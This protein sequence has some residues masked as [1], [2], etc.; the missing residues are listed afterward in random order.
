MAIVGVHEILLTPSLKGFQRTAGKALEGQAGSVGEQAGRTMG[1][2]LGGAL[3]VGAVAVGGAAIAGIGVAITKGFGRLQAIEQ[4]Q[5]TLVG[6]GHSAETVEQ[7]MKNANDAVKG[8]AFGLGDAATVAAQMVASGIKPGEDLE[9]TLTLVG[10]AATIAG[11]GID[12]MGGIFAKAAASNKVQ[13]DVIGQLHDAG[14]PALQ[15]IA[16]EMGVTAEEASKMASGGKVDFETFEAAMTKGMGGAAQESGKTLTGAFNNAMAAV[17]RFGA[18]LIQDVYPQVRDFFNGFIEWMGPVEELG[19]VIGEGLGKALQDLIAW[20]Q[21]TGMPALKGFGDWV[22]ENKDP[23]LAAASA[24]AGLMAGLALYNGVMGIVGWI[25]GLSTAIGAL[26]AA[27]LA[28]PIGIVIGL[29]AALIGVA[30]W[31]YTEFDWFKNIVDTAFRVIGDT[32]SWVWVN[33]IQPTFTALVGF[34]RDVIVPAITWLWENV[35]QPVFGWIGDR[36]KGVWEGVI[37]P[38]FQLMHDILHNVVGPA[39]KW[40]YENVVRPV[41]GW[42]GDRISEV[43]HGVIKPV[44]EAFGRFIEEEV[45][46]RIETGVAII[47]RVWDRMKRLFAEPINWVI[48]TVW[49]NGLKK[50]FDGVA[51]AVGSKARLGRVGLIPLGDSSSKGNSRGTGGVTTVGRRASGGNVHEGK[52]YLVGEL[53]PELIFPHKDGYVATARETSKMLAQG[54]DLSPELSKKAA[55]SHPGQALAP[56]GDFNWGN[57]GDELKRQLG[58]GR[59]L[60]TDQIAAGVGQLG[61]LA[62]GILDPLLSRARSV[63]GGAGKNGELAM[64]AASKAVRMVADWATKQD[65]SMAG[66]EFGGMF[67]GDAGGFHRPSRGPVTSRYGRRWGAHH[68]GI[69]I[70]GG[71]PTYAAWNGVVAKTGW[72]IG[73]GR[74]GIGILLNHGNRHTYYG[75]N[76]VGGVRVRPGQQVKAGQRIGAQGAT[77]NVTGTHLHFEEHRGRAWND[78]NPGYLF[79]DKGGVLPPGL[80]A[81]LNNTGGNEWIFNQQQLGQLDRAVT[82]QGIDYDRLGEVLV[83]KMGGLSVTLD[84]RTTIGALRSNRAWAGA[85]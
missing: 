59:I 84:G 55:G 75:H 63:L 51:E 35:V 48:N 67:T 45:A 31:A 21:G 78:V 74:T 61:N 85:S 79:R 23:L 26:N 14:V 25:K 9:K 70:A 65:E 58:I 17:G 27:M 10:D 11:V 44:L 6:L 20:I 69:D 62:K 52:P 36:I 77:G 30:I 8:T 41:F 46:P 57:A 49:N 33:V 29:I 54:K 37:Q 16:E 43:W 53:G 60:G 82:G 50:A 73:P 24:I 38:V 12:D 13:M 28:N 47:G 83:D 19:K 7:I 1:S 4:A 56:M 42:I 32:I 64:G 72:N 80:N 39:V 76:P 3:K 68:A 15:L 40:F 71:G 22:R 81:V 66:G 34:I 5:A 2:R 18:N